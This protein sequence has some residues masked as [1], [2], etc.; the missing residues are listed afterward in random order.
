MKRTPQLIAA[1]LLSITGPIVVERREYQCTKCERKLLPGPANRLCFKCD[2]F[3][4]K[5]S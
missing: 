1:S 3:E 2:Y 5:N 4:K